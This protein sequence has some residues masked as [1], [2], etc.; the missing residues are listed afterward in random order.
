MCVI[1]KYFKFIKI[2][3]FEN[4]GNFCFNDLGI[5]AFLELLDERSE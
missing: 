1:S 5:D 4:Y 3:I 2:R